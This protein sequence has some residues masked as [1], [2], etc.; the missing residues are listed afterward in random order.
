MVP[1]IPAITDI[2]RYE[3]I[4]LLKNAAPAISIGEY[5]VKLWRIPFYFCYAILSSGNMTEGTVPV[6]PDRPCA[7]RD[8]DVLPVQM[9]NYVLRS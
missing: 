1:E 8:D 9:L 3:L 7:E 4:S 2:L 5:T 6:L